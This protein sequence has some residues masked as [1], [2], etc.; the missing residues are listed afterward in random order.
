MGR[1][2][3]AEQLQRWLEL[4]L[5]SAAGDPLG[6]EVKQH[7]AGRAYGRGVVLL[8]HVHGGGLAARGSE[9]EGEAEVAVLLRARH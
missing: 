8:Q 7:R 1:R 2:M 6:T 3:L 4:L 5:G 9:E